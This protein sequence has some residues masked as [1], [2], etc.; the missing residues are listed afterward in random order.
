M[1]QTNQSSNKVR[2]LRRTVPDDVPQDV[3]SEGAS[4]WRWK[5]DDG[6]WYDY[7]QEDADALE[8]KFLEGAPTADLPMRGWT[9]SFDFTKMAQTNTETGTVRSVQRRAA[10]LV[11]R[12]AESADTG[13]TPTKRP[14]LAAAGAE[15]DSRCEAAPA[16]PAV[17]TPAPAFKWQLHDGSLLWRCCGP[18]PPA[19]VVYGFDM[20]STL[21]ETKSGKT[22]ATDR[23]NWK[24]LLPEVPATLKRL[25]AEGKRVAIFSNQGGIGGKG[26]NESLA[27]AVRGKIDDLAEALGFPLFAFVA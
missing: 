15:E 3:P 4:G 12:P 1:T 10:K 8:A 7:S 18:V 26:W 25:H 20:D 27:T 19:T 5:D 21:I 11:K 22:F 23:R 14:K 2:A 16:A 24:W 13:A 9:Y 6:Q 17:S